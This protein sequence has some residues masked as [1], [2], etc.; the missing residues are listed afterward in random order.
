MQF[1]FVVSGGYGVFYSRINHHLQT[2]RSAPLKLGS[3]IPHWAP[4]CLGK[5]LQP[6]LSSY[7]PWD[8]QSVP[9]YW[10]S[11][12]RAGGVGWVSGCH[13]SLCPTPP[14]P[15]G[16]R[17]TASFPQDGPW[18][19]GRSDR[20]CRIPAIPCDGSE[21]KHVCGWGAGWTCCIFRGGHFHVRRTTNRQ[22]MLIPTWRFGKRCHK[23]ERSE[24]GV[25]RK[26]AHSMCCRWEHSRFPVKN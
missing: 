9:Q 15:L 11:S 21:C 1:C 13:P 17:W 2:L 22:G 5:C 14:R 6:Q 18:R 24:L 26:T 8:V 12:W 16:E 25:P 3:L 20:F 23:N 19:S 10:H 7:E 4:K